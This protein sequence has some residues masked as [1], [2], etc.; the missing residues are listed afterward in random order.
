M[1]GLNE[2]ST[3]PPK[4]TASVGSNPTLSANKIWKG[5]RVGLRRQIANLLKGRI[6]FRRF[7]SSLFRHIFYGGVLKLVEEVCLESK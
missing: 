1:S 6:S 5:G 7:E 2:R 3:K 4:L